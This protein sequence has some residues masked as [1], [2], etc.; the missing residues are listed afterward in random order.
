M[1][2]SYARPRD[3]CHIVSIDKRVAVYMYILFNMLAKVLIITGPGTYQGQ[4]QSILLGKIK[5][6]IFFS[7][8]KFIDNIAGHTY[9]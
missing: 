9:T 4:W 5:L 6:I 3:W 1:T 8:N 2:F 7:T